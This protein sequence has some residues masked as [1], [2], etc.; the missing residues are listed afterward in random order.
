MKRLRET[1]PDPSI[2]QYILR[3]RSN[4][5]FEAQQQDK[6]QSPQSITIPMFYGTNNSALSE[7]QIP[8]YHRPDKTTQCHKPRVKWLKSSSKRE[9]TEIKTDNLCIILYRLRWTTEKNLRKW[10]IKFFFLKTRN[11]RRSR[12]PI[13]RKIST[14]I[15]P[16]KQSHEL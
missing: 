8:I 11:I 2:D 13:L 12:F 16:N 10:V 6:T 4:Y 1:R 9:W 14:T 7:S 5:S 15:S 3:R